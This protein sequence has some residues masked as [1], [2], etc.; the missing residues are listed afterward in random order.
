MERKK[1]MKVGMNE[2][3]SFHKQI[4]RLVLAKLDFIEL[5]IMTTVCKSFFFLLKED[6]VFWSLYSQSNLDITQLP[7]EYTRWK[8]FSLSKLIEWDDSKF[9]ES[10]LMILDDDDKRILI[11]ERDSN[12]WKYSRTKQHLLEGILYPL[13]IFENFRA[14][15]LFLFKIIFF[16]YFLIFLKIFN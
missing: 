10:N 6:E 7:N 2:L 14:L 15:I 3:S 11:D 12:R 1:I 13:L 9:D 16:Y 5:S 8:D 4:W